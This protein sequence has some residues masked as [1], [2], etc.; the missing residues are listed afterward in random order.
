MAT[1]ERAIQIAAQAHAGQFDKGGEAY[2]LHPLRVMLRM[3]S[4]AE[5]IVAVLH[6]V[7]EDSP[8]H[9]IEALSREGFAPEVIEA[10][11]ALTKLPGEGRVAA[12]R[13]AAEH[14][15]ARLVKLADNAENMDLSRIPNPAEKDFARLKEYEEVR[16]I[17]L[18]AGGG[19]G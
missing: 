14:P 2:I 3:Q 18:A 19:Q 17:L 11:R 4:Q 12:A 8:D 13:R 9:S 7:V 6:D 16:S 5:R 10:I 15:I 1:L